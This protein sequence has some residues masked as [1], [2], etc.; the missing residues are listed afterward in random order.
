[1]ENSI[2][3]SDIISLLLESFIIDVILIPLPFVSYSLQDNTGIRKVKKNVHKNF[4]HI[5]R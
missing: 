2:W 5:Y 4:L 1:M 3:T